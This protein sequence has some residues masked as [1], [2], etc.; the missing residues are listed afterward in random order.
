MRARKRAKSVPS[1]VR[2]S[3]S[4]GPSPTIWR[5][6]DQLPQAARRSGSGPPVKWAKI[7]PKHENLHLLHMEPFRSGRV[8][9]GQQVVGAVALHPL[10]E[11]P[12]LGGSRGRSCRVAAAAPRPSAR[13][14]LAPSSSKMPS[15]PV[16]R[17]K[18]RASRSVRAVPLRFSS[19]RPALRAK[20]WS[21]EEAG[22]VLP[23]DSLPQMGAVVI[24]LRV[25]A[26]QFTR[27]KD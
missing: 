6:C 26:T 11:L 17:S 4:K 15:V 14:G 1:G 16:L 5:T 18:T 20:R 23:K 21:A 7:A 10:Q 12:K 19:T 22:E 9:A 13:R 27:E 24:L 2:L 8:E 3:E 25:A